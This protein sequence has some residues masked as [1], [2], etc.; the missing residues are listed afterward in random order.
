[1]NSRFLV[2]TVLFFCFWGAGCSKGVEL[3][4]P[5]LVAVNFNNSTVD[6][7]TFE[8]SINGEAQTPFLSSGA[9]LTRNLFLSV[10]SQSAQITLSKLPQ[11]E[12][13]ADVKFM[14]SVG[15]K[16]LHYFTI[17]QA[18]TG[19]VP[20]ILLPDTVRNVPVKKEGA[21]LQFTYRTTALPDSIQLK[22]YKSTDTSPLDSCLV[23]RYEF[24]DWTS[25]ILSLDYQLEYEMYDAKTHQKLLPKGSFPVRRSDMSLDYNIV[26]LNKDVYGNFIASRLY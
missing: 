12:T 23:R 6:P 13:F 1:M 19:D 10:D 9:G 20:Y 7:F 17:Y 11:R 8:V 18:K 2:F 22:F 5:A 24:S 3:K 25:F 15:K 26:L 4:E 21:R 14:P 16:R